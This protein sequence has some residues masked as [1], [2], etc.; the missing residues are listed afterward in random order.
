MVEDGSRIVDP[1]AWQDPRNGVLYARA[2]AD[3]LA[4]AAPAQAVAIQGRAA[5]YIA[6]IEAVD[7]WITQ[8]LAAIPP[9]RRRII[10]SHDA[11]GYYAARYGITM[12]GVQGI[13]TES[14][15]SARDIARLAAQIRR[16]RIRAVFVET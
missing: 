4:R 16:E 13:N 10:T 14:E 7:S 8:T 2:I 3:G 11:F 6:E 12:R 9:A 1:H 15:P 5:A